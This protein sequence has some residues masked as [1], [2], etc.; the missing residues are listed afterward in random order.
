MPRVNVRPGKKQMHQ[1]CD[2][3]ATIVQDVNAE[4]SRIFLPDRK[5]APARA[6]PCL[7]DRPDEAAR[8]PEIGHAAA[9]VPC[10]STIPAHARIQMVTLPRN[11]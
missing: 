11:A 2:T 3:I 8:M 7:R 9:A 4:A 5:N 10:Q 6:A 1:S